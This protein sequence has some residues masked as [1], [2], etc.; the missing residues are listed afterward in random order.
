MASPWK[1]SWGGG[2][3]G[4]P[5]EVLPLKWR[6]YGEG[7][8]CLLRGFPLRHLVGCWSSWIPGLPWNTLAGSGFSRPIFSPDV[9]DEA[10][11]VRGL[12]AQHGEGMAPLTATPLSSSPR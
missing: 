3:Q 5:K 6:G 2:G 10:H 8:K 7:L 9:G 11:P 4:G 12:M 1:T